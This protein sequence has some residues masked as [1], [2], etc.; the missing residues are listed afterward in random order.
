MFIISVNISDPIVSGGGGEK[1]NIMRGST[2]NSD[3]KK[4]NNL[5]LI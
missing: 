1:Q 4:G 3:N 2:Y 5:F